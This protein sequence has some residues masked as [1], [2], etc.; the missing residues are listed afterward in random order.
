MA[1]TSQKSSKKYF[2]DRILDQARH[3]NIVLSDAEQYM[4]GWT[5]SEKGFEVDQ[6]LIEQFNR[7]TTDKE[8]EQKIVNLLKS[9]Y[10]EDIK[11]DSMLKNAYREAYSILNK[12]DYYILVMIKSAIGSKLTSTLK[13]RVL[14]V[15]A[16][17]ALGA[18]ILGIQIVLRY[19]GIKK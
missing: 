11:K 4:L 14:L 18:S 7:E 3:N 13:D 6:R 15:L 10:V 8:F 5:E 16:A 9:A 2:I 1:F 12:G 17:I 19:F